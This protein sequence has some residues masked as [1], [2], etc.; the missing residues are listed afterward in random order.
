MFF[1]L[2]LLLV[3]MYYILLGCY[4][5]I[6]I[7]VIDINKTLQKENVLNEHKSVTIEFFEHLL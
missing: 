7:Q 2:I 4:I 3:Q 6:Y 5:K 1:K